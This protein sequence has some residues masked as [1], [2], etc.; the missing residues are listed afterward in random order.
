[1]GRGGIYL[2]Y[3]CWSKHNSDLKCP[4]VRK[5]SASPLCNI[6]VQQGI[7]WRIE[8]KKTMTSLVSLVR[9]GR[10]LDALKTRVCVSRISLDG[11]GSDHEPVL[12]RI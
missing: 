5:S 1:M 8:G 6:W 12:H 7:V 9:A 10:V 11:E 3:I 4:V 2:L